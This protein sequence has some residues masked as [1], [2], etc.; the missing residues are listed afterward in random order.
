MTICP[1]CAR[2]VGSAR[3]CPYDGTPLAHL[4]ASLELRQP[5]PGD[6]VDG[7]YR[8][9]AELGRGG[10]GIVYR[11][12]AKGLERPVAIKVLK[13]DM[14]ARRQTVARF[15]REARAS[16]RIDHPNVVRV[17]DFGFAAEGFY[18]LVMELLEGRALS[19]LL[20]DHG[21]LSSRR[22][23]H[24]LGQVASG[25]ARAHELGVVHRDLKPANIM[26]DRRDGDHVT[27]VDFGLS[28]TESGWS[29]AQMTSEGDLLG[30]PDYMAPEQWLG[31][32]VDARA[33]VYAFGVMAYEMLSGVLPFHGKTHVVVMQSH[34]S[35][36]PVPLEERGLT[37]LAPGLDELVLHCLQKKPSERPDDMRA[38]KRALDR[39]GRASAIDP[40]TDPTGLPA[41]TELMLGDLG[42]LSFDE[43][44]GEIARLV[45]V[46][47][48]RLAGLVPTCFPD[49][50]PPDVEAR[51]AELAPRDGA[52]E[53]LGEE[54]ALAR[55]HLEE[56]ARVGREREA[57]LRERLVRAS[58]HVAVQRAGLPEDLAGGSLGPALEPALLDVESAEHH[59]AAHLREET[60]ELEAIRARHATLAR[61]LEEAQASLDLAYEAL[62]ARLREVPAPRDVPHPV[63]MLTR[64]EGAIAAHRAQL[65]R[66]QR[67]RSPAATAS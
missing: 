15:A 44:I 58:V 26:V 8:I 45:R 49:G 54:L 59:L 13:P 11:A 3:Y 21:R 39:M 19:E 28:K 50:A 46:R 36:P 18:Y 40:E 41:G 7:R 62:E 30:T 57:S 34:L 24:L 23:L 60:P 33:D 12:H 22:A 31:Q 14:A 29:G 1:H 42:S 16:S 32:L 47:R 27:L 64:L 56:R 6:L 25:M 63:S 4:A 5:S 35:D 61:A 10:I 55:E 2:D 65:E 67:R 38:V 51:L 37:D 43:V 48:G 9:E 53:R 20:D 52:V 66:L 17:F